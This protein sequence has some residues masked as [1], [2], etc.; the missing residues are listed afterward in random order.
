MS[1]DIN[2]QG[3]GPVVAY[4]TNGLLPLDNTQPSPSSPSK[5]AAEHASVF[6]A[7][8]SFD[9][10]VIALLSGEDAEERAALWGPKADEEHGDMGRLTAVQKILVCLGEPGA[11][12]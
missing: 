1:S 3:F 6:G 7:P 5:G 2:G 4:G 11:T 8:R 9:E 12:G 10:R